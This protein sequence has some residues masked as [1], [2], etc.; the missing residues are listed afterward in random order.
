[1]HEEAK[2]PTIILGISICRNVLQKN[3]VPV[4][5][6]HTTPQIQRIHFLEILSTNIPVPNPHIA[7]I[8]VKAVPDIMLY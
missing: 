1:M 4:N 2:A 6:L 7:V 5:A 3:I 8:I